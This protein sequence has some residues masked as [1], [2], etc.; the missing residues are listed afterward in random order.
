MLELIR[1]FQL[2][3][4]LIMDLTLTSNPKTDIYRLYLIMGRL[5]EPLAPRLRL[6]E[7]SRGVRGGSCRGLS[8]QLEAR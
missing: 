5:A 1:R 4:A 2:N 3:N 6:D 8:P 7:P